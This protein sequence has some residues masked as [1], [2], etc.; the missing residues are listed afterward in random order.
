MDRDYF[1]AT[2][3]VYVPCL[4]YPWLRTVFEYG[5]N[6]KAQVFVEDNGFT[7][8]TIPATFDWVPGQH[9]FLRFRGFG[10][11]AL[12]SHP[13][14]ICS[15]PSNSPDEQSHM[16]FYVRHRGG[17]TA[18]LYHHAMKRSGVSVPVFVDGPYGGI[19]PQKYYSSDRLIVIAGGSGAGWS[20]PFV[21]QF[22][23]CCLTPATK[24]ASAGE[25]PTR[26][27]RQPRRS[28]A[29]PR[30]LRVIVATSDTATHVW[31]HKSVGNLLSKYSSLDPSFDLDVQVYL[32][33][34]AEQQADTSE[35]LA[36]LE[37]AEPSFAEN[38]S[39]QKD[40]SKYEGQ[41][42]SSMEGQEPH[43]RPPLPEIIQEEVAR[44]AETGQSLGVFVCGPGT[45]QNDVRNAVAKANVNVLK[46]P[47]CGV[48][49]HLEHFSWA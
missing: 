46:N 48:Y 16:T 41:G 4:V 7:R 27:T 31:F 38:A 37:T 33:G 32:T 49:L 25:E 35:I 34:Q 3:A 39:M 19:D 5:I 11:H 42:N 28:P 47:T 14:T 30:S 40:G 1:I 18:R 17:F 10:I 43:G 13:F 29:A 20:L 23:R 9:C 21:E 24:E 44:V 36:D 22:V 2:A 26:T 12:T 15:L 45:M 6:Q 8:I